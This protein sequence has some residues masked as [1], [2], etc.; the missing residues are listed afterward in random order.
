LTPCHPCGCTGA[1]S[2][3]AGVSLDL[4]F[5][6]FSV[7]AVVNEPIGND[8]DAEPIPKQ[9]WHRAHHDTAVDCE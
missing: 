1:G 4:K 6:N 8:R 9:V 7:T 3:D 5:A 2:A